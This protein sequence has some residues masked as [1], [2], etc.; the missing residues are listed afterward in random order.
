MKTGIFTLT[1]MFVTLVLLAQSQ[2]SNTHAIQQNPTSENVNFQLFPTQNY[3]TFIKLDTRNG[4]MWQVHFS[5]LEDGKEG[6][7]L[8]NSR[9]LVSKDE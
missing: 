4:K 6:E 9:P 2:T 1:F 5:V 8:L 3:W 7:L